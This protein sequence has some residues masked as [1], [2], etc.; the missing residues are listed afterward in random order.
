MSRGYGS[1]NQHTEYQL[2]YAGKIHLSQC[3]FKMFNSKSREWELLPYS[4]YTSMSLKMCGLWKNIPKKNVSWSL[5][6]TTWGISYNT[7][8]FTLHMDLQTTNSCPAFRR[9]VADSARMPQAMMSH[10]ATIL[11]SGQPC[12]N[13]LTLQ[14]ITVLD[15]YISSTMPSNWVHKCY[16]RNVTPES[17]FLLIFRH[18]KCLSLSLS[19]SHSH[20]IF[21][22]VTSPCKLL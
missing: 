18:Y 21:H 7:W 17:Q 10:L 19:H 11:D 3:T 2:I 14:L 15:H 8:A 9:V 20:T 4:P 22:I 12:F 5:P 16:C 1:T 6:T 13:P